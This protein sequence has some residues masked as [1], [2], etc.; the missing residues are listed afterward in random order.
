MYHHQ[1]TVLFN[2]TIGYNIRYGRP[3]ATD[4]E[5]EAAARQANIHDMI[6]A[7]PNK[8]D[9]KVGERGLMLSG[10]SRFFSRPLYR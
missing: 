10:I 1:D 3:D 2:D 8:Y 7:L 4:A 6:A 9:T 5:I